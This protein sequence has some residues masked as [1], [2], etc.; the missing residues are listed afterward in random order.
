MNAVYQ[1]VVSPGRG[2]VGERRPGESAWTITVAALRRLVERSRRFWRAEFDVWR[3][4]RNV[5]CKR[6]GDAHLG[7]WR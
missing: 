1:K 5:A 3:S 2:S 4:I 6:I 7:S